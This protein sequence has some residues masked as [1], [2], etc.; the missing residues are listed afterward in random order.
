[1]PKHAIAQALTSSEK[2]KLTWLRGALLAWWGE[3][4]EAFPWRQSGATVYERV[5]VEVLLQ[6][7]RRE[8]VSAMYSGFFERFPSWN[9]LATCSEEELGEYLQLLGLWRR[10]TASLG[11]LAQYADERGGALRCSPFLG[12]DLAL[13][14]LKLSSFR[15]DLLDLIEIAKQRGQTLLLSLL[16]IPELHVLVLYQRLV[17]RKHEHTHESLQKNHPANTNENQAKDQNDLTVKF[18]PRRPH[19]DLSRLNARSRSYRVASNDDDLMSHKIEHS[20]VCLPLHHQ[21]LLLELCSVGHHWK[22][23]GHHKTG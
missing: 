16:A 21:V 18:F 10:R 6:R 11:S 23:I 8:T 7:T 13:F 20:S 4:C 2:R 14:K 5:C 9:A 12:Q 3:N 19:L 22:R 17:F 15:I 1:M